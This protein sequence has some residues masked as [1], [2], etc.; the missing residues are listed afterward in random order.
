MDEKLHKCLYSL[1]DCAGR[2]LS[3][4]EGQFLMVR[5]DGSLVVGGEMRRSLQ[6]VERLIFY[7]GEHR[8]GKPMRRR[9]LV[10]GPIRSQLEL[11]VPDFDNPGFGVRFRVGNEQIWIQGMGLYPAVISD[12]L[13]CAKA[14]KC[15]KL[16]SCLRKDYCRGVSG[17]FEKLSV[18]HL[19]LGIAFNIGGSIHRVI[20]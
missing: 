1:L 12:F 3:E 6:T 2:T 10:C 17:L 15:E 16:G 8:L 20:M 4:N 11:F 19:G 7:L 14:Y 18:P 9:G 13:S 5:G